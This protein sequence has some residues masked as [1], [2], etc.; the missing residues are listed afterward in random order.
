MPILASL[1]WAWFKI[2]LFSIGGGYVA[3]P[4]IQEEIIAHQ[5]W[6]TLSEYADIVAV[7][8][9]TPGPIALNCASFVGCK[10]AG[11]T[12]S[13]TATLG[14]ISAPCAIVLTL[15]IL[16]KRFGNLPAVSALLRGIKPAVVGLIASVACSFILLSCLKIDSHSGLAVDKIHFD[17]IAAVICGISFFSLQRCQTNPILVMM[18]AA[19][20]GILL[21][22]LSSTIL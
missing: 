17:P 12:G 19:V 8:E 21:Y 22:G 1:Y 7:A 6:L 14:C 13:L 18:G 20:A 2:G 15:A 9:M 11:W 10:L 5:H 3:L 16:F 4:L